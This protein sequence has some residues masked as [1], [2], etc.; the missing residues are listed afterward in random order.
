M[1]N[2]E[3]EKDKKR[4]ILSPAT[5]QTAMHYFTLGEGGG[6]SFFLC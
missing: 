2:S 6:R 4:V 1:K 3:N 5:A